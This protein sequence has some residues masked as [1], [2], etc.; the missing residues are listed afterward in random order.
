MK[1]FLM[2]HIRRDVVLESQAGR[3]SKKA[4]NVPSAGVPYP[5]NINVISAETA[6]SSTVTSSSLRRSPDECLVITG[7]HEAA[8]R[9]YCK[10]LESC[11]T[12]EA[13]KADFRRIC[14]VILANHL[15]LELIVE[16]PDAG[17]FTRQGIKLGTAL[18]FL[19]D[20]HE[21]DRETQSRVQCSGPSGAVED[22]LDTVA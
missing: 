4:D 21:W 19:R 17:F 18:R 1:M 20:I 8:V 13:Y 3:K 14:Q 12:E 10:W 22:I 7:P 11:A 6:R 15:D 5:I 16:A 9:E 2:I